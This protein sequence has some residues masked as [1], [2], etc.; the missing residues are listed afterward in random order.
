MQITISIDKSRRTILDV[1]FVTMID[2]LGKE[3]MMYFGNSKTGELTFIPLPE[4]CEITI[5]NVGI[6]QKST[7][8]E[9]E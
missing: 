3:P 8:K 2:S 5:N 9:I 6:R 7:A 4:K 1:R